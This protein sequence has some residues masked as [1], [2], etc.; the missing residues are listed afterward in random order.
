M[1]VV[2]VA[3]SAFI[4]IGAT[5]TPVHVG[6]IA[7][8]IS[9]IAFFLLVFFGVGHAV[10]NEARIDGPALEQAMLKSLGLE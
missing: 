10:A 6:S 9:L 4:I 1:A 8:A 2:I 3:G 5:S 7:L